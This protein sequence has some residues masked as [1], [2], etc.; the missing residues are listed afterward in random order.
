MLVD[1]RDM[2][3]DSTLEADVCV[4]GAGVAGVTLT[5]Q[6]HAHGLAVVL[7]ES[8]RRA[9]SLSSV[10]LLNPACR[11]AFFTVLVSPSVDERR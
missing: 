3:D 7:L 2:Q 1:L 9:R 11:I 5:R 4:V 10:E 6:L 8:C